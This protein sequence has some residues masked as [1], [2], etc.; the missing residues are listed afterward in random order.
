[1]PEHAVRFLPDDVTVTVTEGESLLVAAVKADIPI[2]GSC[3]GK[4]TCGRCRMTVREGRVRSAGYGK[5][6]AEEIAEG[7]V[8]A[9]Q[10]VLETDVL[11]E[12]PPES[13]LAAH[14]VEQ[15]EGV[16]EDSDPCRH[17][18]CEPLY[19][20][21]EL[22]LSP[23]TL[24][25]PRD[26]ASRL[27]TAIRQ[28][29]G[30]EAVDL[31]P[32]ILPA[33]PRV[34]REQNWR[35]AAL[36]EEGDRRTRVVAVTGPGEEP[37]YGLAVDIGTTTVVVH[38]IELGTMTTVG[39]RGTYNGQAVYGDDVISRI[40]HAGDG[41]NGLPQLQSSVMATINDL[42]A[43]LLREKGITPSD[44]KVAMCA[45]N[46]TMTHL[47]LGIDPGYIRLEPYTPTVNEPPPVRAGRLGLAIHPRALVHCL[48]GIASYVG[49]DITAGALYTGMAREE[50][51]TLFVDIGTNGEMVLGHQ[52][53]LVACSCSAGPAFEG[54]G[55]KF[56][57][58]AMDGAI[59]RVAV[60]KGGGRVEVATVGS[61]PPVGICGSGLID[62]LSALRR[63]GVIDRSGQFTAE[64]DTP[65][66]RDG[67]DGREFVLVWRDRTGRGTDIT[68]NEAEI[69]NLIRAKGAVFAAIRTMLSMV[70]LPVEAI[71]RIIIAGGF[72]RY[73]NIR[74]AIN[75]GL[76]PDLPLE[77]YSYVGNSS[78]KGARLVLLSRKAREQARELAGKMTYLELSV[79]N[80]FFDE[81]V[82]ALFL[83]HT[84]MT[85]FP[86]V[87]D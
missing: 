85:L 84:D 10:S 36:L 16:I 23:P 45:G 57:M 24:D 83:P 78:V 77:K 82:S 29:T 41:E 51:L 70:G 19:R 38:L 71:E 49:G 26:D 27:K 34:L 60:S 3:G 75:I 22:I 58:R 62:M 40:M 31:D 32:E 9:C 39:V 20:R 66:V 87:Q 47:F 50:A 4:G 33:L 17:D 79:G 46:T 7:S 61:M 72:G 67:E 44:V 73:I 28:A 63:A 80:D 5:L 56:G 68:I 74:E 8:L 35:I 18:T 15:A 42:T 6:T 30:L 11:V 53:W 12:V 1:M 81:F 64:P 52:E 48:P 25:D 14:Q 86:S 13:R 54:S 65:R 37:L 76:L 43:E 59:E 55:I 69:K 2:R 21:V